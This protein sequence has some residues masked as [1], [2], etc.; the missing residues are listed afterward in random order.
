MSRTTEE[1]DKLLAGMTLAEKADL[2]QRLAR[3][4]G[5][6]VPGIES[7]P[8]VCGGAACIIRTRI[9]IW[10]L[11]EARRQGFTEA[12]FLRSYPSLRAEDLANAWAYVRVHREEIDERIRE[13]QE[14]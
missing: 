2:L 4:V 6:V 1:A 10:L 3:D 9:P 14:A 11:E 5:G 12:E 8:G 13:N 7:T